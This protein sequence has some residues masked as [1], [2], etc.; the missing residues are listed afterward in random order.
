MALAV[1]DYSFAI[2]NLLPMAAHS[3]Q[4]AITTYRLLAALKTV[5]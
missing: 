3:V 2:P 1:A 4:A 5:L